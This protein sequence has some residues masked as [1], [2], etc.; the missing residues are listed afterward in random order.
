MS[1]LSDASQAKVLLVD[2]EPANRLALRAALENLEY[3]LLEAHSGEEMPAQWVGVSFAYIRKIESGKL[4]FGEYR[5]EG[6]THKLAVDLEA[7][8]DE[9]H[10]LTGRQ[11]ARLIRQPLDPLLAVIHSDLRCSAR[12]TRSRV[13]A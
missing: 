12:S 1:V 3:D 9:M 8:E 4:D 7:D 13:K 11:F 10:L 2:D 5:S 6:L